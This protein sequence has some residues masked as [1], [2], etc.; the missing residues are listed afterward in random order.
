MTHLLRTLA[1]GNRGRLALGLAFTAT[2]VL[3]G[4]GLLGISGWF[5]TATGLAG[6]SVAGALAFDV[7][8]PAA[9]I[10][11][12]AILRTGS[13]YGER[14]ATHDAT[15]AALARL[16]ERLFRGWAGADAAEAL[17]R[18]PSRLAV[19]PDAGRRCP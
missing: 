15:L 17:R 6:A 11:L 7:F 3:A 10:R 19:P 2:T 1:A 16:R 5:I 12:L 13:R 9:A 4:L 8:A 14:V 18:R